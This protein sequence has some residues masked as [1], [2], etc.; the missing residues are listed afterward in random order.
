MKNN[1]ANKITGI[2]VFIVFLSVSILGG[3]NYYFGYRQTLTS[4]GVELTGCANITTGII[5][6]KNLEALLEGDQEMLSAVNQAIEWTV[7]HKPIFSTHYILS[8][9]G[10]VVA[11]DSHLQKIGVAVGDQVQLTAEALDH[12]S[13]GHMYYTDIY[14]VNGHERQTGYAPI[15]RDHNPKNEM[16]AINAI[17]FDGA[18]IRE[19]TWETNQASLILALVLPILAAIVTFLFIKKI[20][21]PLAKIQEHVEKLAQGNLV[22]EDL[23]VETTDE[24]GNLAQGFNQMRSEL[25]TIIGEVNQ[26]AVQTTENSLRVLNHSEE[27]Q[28][29]THTIAHSLTKTN[30]LM[31]KQK[32]LTDDAN[33]HLA[34]ISDHVQT[35]TGNIRRSATTATKTV[36]LANK[37]N[38][39]VSQSISHMKRIHHKTEEANAITRSLNQHAKEIDQVMTFIGR[40][41]TQTNLLAL[42]ASIEA[43]RAQEHGRGFLVVAEEVRELSVQTKQAAEQVSTLIQRL[44]IESTQSVQTG[45]DVQSIVAEGI[46]QI[47]ETKEAFALIDLAAR[48]AAD[49]TTVISSETEEIEK[50]TLQLV[51]EIKTVTELGKQVI[52]TSQETGTQSEKQMQTMSE[53]VQ[54]SRNLTQLADQ[55]KQQVGRFQIH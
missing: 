40:I 24:L 48:E 51:S 50:W 55:L 11:S 20:I 6:A 16:I 12:L 22:L 41:S 38:Q 52:Q 54:V 35:M 29:T 17:D 37:G 10:R 19:R 2:V 9:E 45:D 14:E 46:E 13:Q 28:E 27:L 39:S 15:F 43:A 25:K 44:Q 36:D 30:G 4:A 3:A 5:D 33:Q 8:N 42:N 47:N 1:I 23:P 32:T 49:Q 53:F 26:A 7:E 21:R 18:V 31:T 34:Q